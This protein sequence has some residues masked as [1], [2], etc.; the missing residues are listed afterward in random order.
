MKE[1]TRLTEPHV[2]EM[3][4]MPQDEPS[5]DKSY[6]LPYEDDDLQKLEERFAGLIQD[7]CDL[8]F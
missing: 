3:H 4:S 1:D 2:E 8:K 5:I 6:T 7:T